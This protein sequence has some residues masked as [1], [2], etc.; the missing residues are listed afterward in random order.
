MT[1]EQ[2]KCAKQ[3]ELGC[4]LSAICYVA[5]EG[6]VQGKGTERERNQGRQKLHPSGGII[7]SS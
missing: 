3:K 2:N 5:S 6:G 7:P 1:E 4:P